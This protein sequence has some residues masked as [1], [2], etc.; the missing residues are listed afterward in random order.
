[1]HQEKLLLMLI[2]PLI[3]LNPPIQACKIVELKIIFN[4]LGTIASI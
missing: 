1:L 3:L 2:S 4:N